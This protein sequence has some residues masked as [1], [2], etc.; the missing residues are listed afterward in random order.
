ME[1]LT[2]SV[3]LG[4][5]SQFTEAR[6]QFFSSKLQISFFTLPF[7]NSELIFQIFSRNLVSFDNIL[8]IYQ[9]AATSRMTSASIIHKSYQKLRFV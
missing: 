9:H 6:D 2:W 1:F 3:S 4:H 8:F 5:G 7:L